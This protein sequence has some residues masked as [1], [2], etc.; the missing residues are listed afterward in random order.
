MLMKDK[1]ALVTGGSRG[2]G[3]SIVEA[4]LREGADVW[5]LST[6]ESPHAEEIGAIAK[7]AGRKAVWK[8]CAVD[9]E[10][11]VVRVVQ[12]VFAEEG[13][14][15]VLVNNAGITKDGLVFRM[16]R[17]D[18]QAVLDVNLTGAF[19]FCREV[20]SR[21]IKQRSGSIINMSSVVG[22]NGNGG[23]CNYSASKAGLIGLTKSLAKEVASR[24]VRV[25]AVAPGFIGTDMTA[26]LKDEQK[27]AIL[28]SVPLGRIADPIEIA[29]ACLYLGS[30]LSAYV[31]GQVLR[32][33]GGMGM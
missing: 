12:E 23:Q 18:W 1:V 15:D 21:M 20:S 25:N 9:D 13:R 24:G 3:L 33:D 4:F 5:F 11:E 32:V 27:Q 2:I 31:T 7:E 19:L 16:K 8:K 26:N 10:A 30:D 28:A 14:V 22:V 29:N 6:K 17:E